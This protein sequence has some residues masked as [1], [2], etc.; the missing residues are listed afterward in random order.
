MGQDLPRFAR[1]AQEQAHSRSDC[2]TGPG[3]VG[4]GTPCR[5]PPQGQELLRGRQAWPPLAQAHPGGWQYR[6]QVPRGAKMHVDLVGKTLRVSASTMAGGE[7]CT[8]ACSAPWG[9]LKA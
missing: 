1:P 5:A 4:R 9:A 8:P 6:L 3:L 2:P 7:V